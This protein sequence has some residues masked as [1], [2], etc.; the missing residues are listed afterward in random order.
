MLA[1]PDLAKIEE[2]IG[3]Y[4]FY[5][6]LVIPQ[7]YELDPLVKVY[8][9]ES[10][11]GW[12]SMFKMMK[13]TKVDTDREDRFFNNHKKEKEIEKNDSDRNIN[14][15]SIRRRSSIRQQ[16]ISSKSNRLSRFVDLRGRNFET[17]M[18]NSEQVS[19]ISRFD[20]RSPYN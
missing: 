8:G 12:A 3:F 6:I 7:R 10:V 16:F 13:G 20:I 18:N 4:S 11:Q 19:K 15:P 2:E 5:G 17:K 14:D 1:K 9:E